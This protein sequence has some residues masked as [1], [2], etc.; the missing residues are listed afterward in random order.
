MPKV[1]ILHSS[2]DGHTV[3]ICHRIASSL[4]TNGWAA[5]LA[6]IDAY[7]DAALA[8]AD[9]LVIG[10]SIRYG[11]HRPAVEKFIASHLALLEAKTSALFS[12]GLV[13]R[14]PEKSEPH[15]NPYLR[16]FLSRIAWKPKIAAVFAGRLDYP[17]YRFFDRQMIR[18][19]MAITGGPTDPE[20]V[21]E[22]TDWKAVEAFAQKIAAAHPPV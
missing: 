14:K 4:E 2:V 13:A 3:E 19:I 5:T 6:A 16:K 1:L 17:R 9:A 22:Y 7:D 12:V 11:H 18:L 15:T 10:A 21:I 8:D 20:T